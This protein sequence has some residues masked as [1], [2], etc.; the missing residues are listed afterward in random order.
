MRW[1]KYVYI[2]SLV[3][4]SVTVYFLWENKRLL[5]TIQPAIVGLPFLI[6]L[7]SRE[8][9]TPGILPVE[10]F[11]WKWR[12]LV[13]C[14]A[15]LVFLALQLVGAVAGL[16]VAS[17][18]EG[19]V[20]LSLL[21]AIEVDLLQDVAPIAMLAWGLP[22]FYLSGRWTGRRARRAAA[23]R[24]GI[25]TIVSASVLG[26]LVSVATTLVL[27]GVIENALLSQILN[28][29]G[30]PDFFLEALWTSVLVASAMFL[31]YWRGRRQVSGTYLSYLLAKASAEARQKIV[32]L[33]HDEAVRGADGASDDG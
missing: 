25:L 9:R 18:V 11:G 24:L 28:E 22:I 5:A 20:V 29:R 19:N 15:F 32:A 14:G 30:L 1:I 21:P 12:N 27:S 6:D 2:F 33:A 17:V 7:L 31:G 3:V 16:I 8:R 13:I 26:V 10:E 23:V 4:A